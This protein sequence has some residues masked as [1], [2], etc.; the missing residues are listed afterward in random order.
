M[1]TPDGE[2]FVFQNIQVGG[3]LSAIHELNPHKLLGP[4]K[5]PSWSIY[6]ALCV[7]APPLIYIF[8][9]SLRQIIC[10]GQSGVASVAPVFIKV[11]L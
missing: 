8:I 1:N 6:D 10:A 9:K 2:S 7:I 5:V 11:M 4:G 3:I